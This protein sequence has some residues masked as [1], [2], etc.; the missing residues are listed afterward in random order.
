MYRFL[1]TVCIFTFIINFGCDNKKSDTFIFQEVPGRGFS[2][3]IRKI[4][5][6]PYEASAIKRER[7]ISNYRNLSI[8]MTQEEVLSLLG[9]PDTMTEKYNKTRNLFLGTLWSYYLHRHEAKLANDVYDQMITLHFDKM[10]KLYFALP[11]NIR[12]LIPKGSSLPM[13]N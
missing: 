10:G 2:D 9:E 6:F 11:T 13:R 12:G 7:I 8:G 3:F 5:H 1:L 4:D